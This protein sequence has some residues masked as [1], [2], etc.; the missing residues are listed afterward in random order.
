MSQMTTRA[1]RGRFKNWNNCSHLSGDTNRL[2]KGI[3]LRRHGS[4][5]HQTIHAVQRRKKNVKRNH[6]LPLFVS[7]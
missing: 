2:T 3:V 6:R 4:G 5:R 1:F 7:M